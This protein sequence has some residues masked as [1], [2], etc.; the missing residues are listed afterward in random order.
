MTPAVRVTSAAEAAARDAAAIAAGIPSRA[1]MQRAGAA[2][3]AEIA[4]R[5][6]RELRR[7]ILVLAGPGNNGGDAWVVA[8]ALA[9]AGVS[10]RVTAV[11]EPR[12]D[13]ARA[14]RELSRGLVEEGS[15]PWGAIVVDG[16][17]G[18]GAKAAPRDEIA[19][20]IASMNEARRHGAVVVALDV[21]SGLDA[22]TGDAPG[23]VV[24]ADLTLT[25]GTLKRGLLLARGIAGRIV[26]LDIGLGAVGDEDCAPVLASPR[27]VRGAVPPIPADA[28]K[29]VR[30]K[31][32]I[33][34]GAQGM[35]GACLL[36]AR[37]AMKSG[38]GMTRLIV[39]SANLPVVQAA[40][41]EALARAWPESD[42]ALKESILEWADGVLIGPGLGDTAKARAL[43]ERV[44]RAWRGPVVVDA[45]GLNVFKGD[46]KTLGALLSDRPA[47]ITPHPA[48][49]ARLT[50]A[51]L[52]G[53][54][55]QRFDVGGE[56]ARTLGGAVLLKGVPT[57]VS[58]ADGQRIVSAA[59]TPALA[60]AG[61][62]DLLAGL[63][64]TLLT[65]TSDALVSG[66][67][68][69]WLHGRAAELAAT[70]TG[71]RGTTLGDI[72]SAMSRVWSAWDDDSSYPVLAELPPVM[73]Q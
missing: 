23:A 7:G 26:A 10:V 1:L 44:L 30:K 21:P 27:W 36:A 38:I 19:S 51:S 16:L 49:L 46:V 72:E 64:A 57:I 18:T 15:A 73:E 50:G 42:T 29:G 5:Y 33:I 12:T 25:F 28:H 69:A 20:A 43:V 35:V 70:A 31:L 61:S 8:R 39:T 59:G 9:T 6:P 67:C 56:L 24:R 41:P 71:T 32:A 66:A 60:A 37:A 54:L 65:Q 17:L 11:G 4:R 13:D 68:A 63:A 47:L 62:G 2:A 45:D 22:T 3:A 53:V 58:S 48:E 34:G 52:A 40:L 14:E 55:E